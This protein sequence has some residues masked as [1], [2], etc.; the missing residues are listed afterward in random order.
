[1]TFKI[2]AASILCILSVASGFAQTS[3]SSRKT[4][5]AAAKLYDNFNHTFI[6]PTKWIASWQCGSPGMECVREIES[7]QLRLRARS[8]GATNS[9]TGTQFSN[10]GVNL[11]NSSV[12]DISVQVTVRNSS[13]QDCAT[14]PGVAHSQV[15]VFGAFF[16]GGSGITADDV[17]AYLQLDRYP[18]QTPQTVEVGGFVYYQGQ[19]FDNV[20]L[21]AVNFGE[22]VTVELQWDQPGHQFVVSLFRPHLHTKVKQSMPYAI[23]D[24]TAAVSPFKA[25]NANVYP[26]NCTAAQTSA[27]LDVLFDNVMTN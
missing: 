2:P 4:T 9:D 27:D 26:A 22:Q 15:L 6:D 19:F 18:S 20:D 13:P 1:M 10:S 23:S 7:G 24:T 3:T 12:S 17:Q 25:M 5:A 16:N 21:G 8:Y 11:A 14:N